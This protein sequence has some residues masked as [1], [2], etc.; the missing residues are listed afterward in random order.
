MLKGIAELLWAVVCTITLMLIP[1][2]ILDTLEIWITIIEEPYK[3]Y[4]SLI[5]GFLLYYVI[6]FMR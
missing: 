3:T 6:R 4:I 2:S 1:W 5:I